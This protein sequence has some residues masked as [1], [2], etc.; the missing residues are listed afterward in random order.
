MGFLKKLFGSSEN[1]VI[2][3]GLTDKGKVREN[4][5]D[6]FAIAEDRN[7]F[8][9]ADGMG[10]HRAGE[11]ASKLAAESFIKIL[12]QEKIKDIRGN[13]AAIQHTVISTFY[14]VNQ[15]VMDEAARAKAQKG[16]GCTLVMCLVDGNTAYISHVGDVRCYL[17][18]REGLRQV[19]HDHSAVV[20]SDCTVAGE[21]VH[22]KRN[23]VTMGIGFP[24]AEDPEFHQIP[25]KAGEKLLLC[26]DG[27]WGML[28]DKKIS[29]IMVSGYSPQDICQELVGQ[30]NNAGGQDNVTAL[31]IQV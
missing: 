22:K 13:P 31:V 5:E 17:L 3:F 24:F 9:V 6:C 26:S 2:G 20:D 10:G 30:A 15:N 18:D 8:V 28:T 29:D 12:S 27:L 4:N 23:I 16:M 7:L 14:T 11:V 25:I 1:R 19:T 21:Q